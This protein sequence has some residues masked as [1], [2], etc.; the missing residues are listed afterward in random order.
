MAKIAKIKNFVIMLWR[1]CE[2]TSGKTARMKT[3]PT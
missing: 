3:V 1:Y 2:R